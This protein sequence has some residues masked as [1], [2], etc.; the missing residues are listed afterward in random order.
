MNGF[1]RIF[2]CSLYWQFLC[3]I[4]FINLEY[5]WDLVFDHE[6]T[7]VVK[8]LWCAMS[9]TRFVHRLAKQTLPTI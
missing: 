1:D 9:C 5:D 4:L 8:N 3:V 2:V 6:K 7:T